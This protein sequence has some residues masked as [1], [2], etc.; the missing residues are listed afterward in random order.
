MKLI[1]LTIILN[2]FIVAGAMAD[3]STCTPDNIN[4]GERATTTDADTSTEDVE[5][6]ATDVNIE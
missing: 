6:P 4:N 3:T 5:K 1:L 2:V